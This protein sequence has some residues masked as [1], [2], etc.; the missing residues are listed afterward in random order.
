MGPKK[1]DKE[2]SKKDKKKDEL[3]SQR[4]A[5]LEAE[6]KQREVIAR[7]R[8]IKNLEKQTKI[9]EKLE[10]K[11]H[12]ERITI[13]QD[14]IKFYDCLKYKFLMDRIKK[15]EIEE[16]NHYVRCDELPNAM[17]PSLLNMHLS[18]WKSAKEHG[19]MDN[20]LESV[21]K[22]INLLSY[23]DK[24]IDV[25]LDASER[26]IE[27]WKQVRLSYR[28]EI[29]RK[30]DQGTYD[31]IREI[32]TK[33]NRIDY[34]TVDYKRFSEN[35]KICMWAWLPFPISETNKR[36]PPTIDY[37]DIGI[38]VRLPVPYDVNFVVVR[39][40]HISFDTL[41][42][43]SRTWEQPLR[44][45]EGNILDV[46]D[47]WFKRKIELGRLKWIEDLKKFEEE[48]KRLTLEKIKST[49]RKKLLPKLLPQIMLSDISH[50]KTE[51]ISVDDD[52]DIKDDEELSSF[53]EEKEE[54]AEDKQLQFE[55][56]GIN[57]NE[58]KEFFKPNIKEDI[59]DCFCNREDKQNKVLLRKLIL[60][61]KERNLRTSLKSLKVN[62]RLKKKLLNYFSDLRIV[63]ENEENLEDDS[64][65]IGDEDQS[66]FNETRETVSV[67]KLRNS[68]AIS[69][70][71]NEIN[72]RKF[73]M[74]GGVYYLD[75]IKHVPQKFPLKDGSF[76]QYHIG[77]CEINRDNFIFIYEPPKIEETNEDEEDKP[78]PDDNIDKLINIEIIL[79]DNVLWFEAPAPVLWHN[80]SKIWSNQHVYDVKFN[81]EKQTINFKLGRTLPIGLSVNRFYNLPYQTWEL[82]PGTADSKTVYFSLTASTVML[83]FIIKGNQLALEKLQNTPSLVLNPF[84]KKFYDLDELM[85]II[86]NHGLD[87]FPS[88][89][90]F[91]Y[92]EGHSAKDCIIEEQ[93]YMG[94]AIFSQFFQFSWSRWNMLA[95]WGRLVYQI[96]QV[97]SRKQL[98][99]YIMVMSDL[100]H[101]TIVAC[102]EVSP[103]F[104]EESIPNIG[105][106]PDLYTLLKNICSP[107]VKQLVD[108]YDTDLINTVFDLL[109]KTKS[110]AEDKWSRF[111]HVLKDYFTNRRLVY[112]IRQVYSRKQLPDYIMVMSDLFHTTIVACTEVSPA[113]SEESIPNI[114]FNPD[115]YT[116][117]K[118]ILKKYFSCLALRKDNLGAQ[119]AI[120]RS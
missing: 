61:V 66:V 77:D 27:N 99:D 49:V 97:Y 62:E 21:E 26:K 111:F 15:R 71:P 88:D 11:L 116:L 23:L 19:L 112:Q 25:P 58:L 96:R 92:I 18:Y 68:F 54:L 60:Q 53:A 42:D 44:P 106:N 17:K 65:Q 110:E 52:D 56:E 69:V 9:Q 89:D 16:W 46:I 83:E 45:E 13:L 70:G 30:L 43:S 98:P 81:D 113:F 48:K 95:G 107:K 31:I 51:E 41:S 103:A 50:T 79:P 12:S 72:L 85:K 59:L 74:L 35:I 55:I 117:L 6:E 64:G 119:A 94:M 93:V 86:K 28:S 40:I 7:L 38:T 101:T 29:L 82:R 34:W 5:K 80:D 57:I 75:L 8:E 84:L 90:S 102:T 91:I 120:N 76:V 104:S 32:E 115:L 22:Y 118:N 105:F 63:Y 37:P 2:K 73:S 39:V 3:E 67:P 108:D 78:P 109:R 87:V 14:N 114:G 47:Y 10:I 4:L 20:I 33:M 1:K 24:L 100:F 36:K